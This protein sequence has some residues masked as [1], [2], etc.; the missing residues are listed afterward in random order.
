MSPGDT[1]LL[2][3]QFFLRGKKSCDCVQNM[4]LLIISYFNYFCSLMN[5]ILIQY[6]NVQF[7]TVVWFTLS[8]AVKKVKT[9]E[10]ECFEILKRH[11]LSAERTNGLE[12]VYLEINTNVYLFA[13]KTHSVLTKM[14]IVNYNNNSKYLYSNNYFPNH[15]S[16]QLH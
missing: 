3:V 12:F 5:C 13:R 9:Y 11:E 7:L 14:S 15:L 16:K 4:I 8:D 6:I 1:I 10:L 2:N